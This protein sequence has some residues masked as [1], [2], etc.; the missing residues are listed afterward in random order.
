MGNEQSADFQ[1]GALS[2]SETKSKTFFRRSSTLPS[3][4][5]APRLK[6]L[7]D[8]QYTASYLALRI[9]NFSG[10]RHDKQ[11][12][13]IEKQII[14]VSM[15]LQKYRASLLRDADRVAADGVQKNISDCLAALLRKAQENESNVGLDGDATESSSFVA[16]NLANETNSLVERRTESSF[17]SQQSLQEQQRKKK[18]NRNAK[19]RQSVAKVAPKYQKR[20]QTLQNLEKTVLEL[21]VNIT[22][23]IFCQQSDSFDKYESK[24]KSICRDLELVD[25]EAHSPL[26]EKKTELYDILI[27]CNNNIKKA[28]RRM[29]RQVAV[30]IPDY[31]LARSEMDSLEE[32][33][34]RMEALLQD[35]TCS[36][37]S[38]KVKF[39]QLLKRVDDVRN[40]TELQERKKVASEVIRS[41]LSKIRFL[42]IQKRLNQ[43]VSQV[44][45]FNGAK[46]S[47]G[48]VK[49]DQELRQLWD[50]V[51]T[52]QS[53]EERKLRVIGEIQDAI[54]TLL[55]RADG[56]NQESTSNAVQTQSSNIAH[57]S[58]IQSEVKI[59]APVYQNNEIYKRAE[60]QEQQVQVINKNPVPS[61]REELSKQKQ[62]E[63]I[64]DNFIRQWHSLKLH[65][66]A[67]SWSQVEKGRIKIKL[68]NIVS[69]IQ[70]IL[71]AIESQEKESAAP[72]ESKD[73][74]TKQANQ[75]FSKPVLHVK[76]ETVETAKRTSFEQPPQ[77]N[78][79]GKPVARDIGERIDDNTMYFNFAAKKSI[80]SERLAELQAVVEGIKVNV[81]SFNGAIRN[82]EYERIKNSIE[83]CV[84]ELKSLQ[85]QGKE[86]L[87]KVYELAELLEIKIAENQSMSIS[88]RAK[89][90][91]LVEKLQGLRKKVDNFTG[92]YR[93][94]LYVKIEDEF[95][96]LINEFDDLNAYGDKKLLY[97]I[98]QT[99]QKAQQYL[100]ILECKSAKTGDVQESISQKRA[101]S[102]SFESIQ[103]IRSKLLEIKDV[104]ENF[105]GVA[106]D[107]AYQFLQKELSS[108]A[109]EL[110]EIEDNGRSSIRESKQQ[111]LNYIEEMRKYLEQKAQHQKDEE[112]VITPIVTE[113]S[114]A[115]K[116]LEQIEE[117]FAATAKRVES[118]KGKQ[119]DKLYAYLDEMLIMTLIALDN[120]HVEDDGMA[121]RKNYL[122]S[123]VHQF[124]KLLSEKAKSK[125]LEE[126]GAA[127]LDK[128]RRICNTI[129]FEIDCRSEIDDQS[130][131]EFN[132]RL[133]NLLLKIDGIQNEDEATKHACK[134]YISEVLRILQG[135]INYQI[136]FVSDLDGV[137]V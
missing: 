104:A 78:K 47:D 8:F 61:P 56:L 109:K 111:Y 135:K 24:I 11:Y 54:Q 89:L 2:D 55:K 119:S 113:T 99:K 20:M 72:K 12:E 81:A 80:S 30:D 60:T 108:C 91:Q 65:A 62:L 132:D 7:S 102:T 1:S 18:E 14:E 98:H 74:E 122:S 128:I 103:K 71:E 10:V 107:S 40:S 31:V 64:I 35:D 28:R 85:P 124:T 36:L 133:V 58:Q 100:K 32:E 93:N 3:K 112:Y 79:I 95:Q 26:S 6:N 137:Q 90:K 106:S 117:S 134:E 50:E 110:N 129:K 105:M 66:E 45:G 136:K 87:E 68:A 70:D 42:E 15:E 130:Y 19:N 29:Q 97:A 22:N 76:P 33:I 13:E 44:Y 96:I 118:F 48:F 120:L 94:I 51:S 86:L 25:V 116:Q 27:K 123:K 37:E 49:L 83:H 17:Q 73:D 23:A 77:Q 126:D 125:K 92:T 41:N 5:K 39:E 4:M 34:H 88:T 114:D 101:S 59:E 21:K 63:E 115:H 69:N 131:N 46:Y 67:S 53:S 38:L 127:T 75:A 9:Q 16:E 57:Q 121:H 52:I 43:L 82:A 84:N